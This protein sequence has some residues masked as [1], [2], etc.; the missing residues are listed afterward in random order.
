MLENLWIQ[1]GGMGLIGFLFYYSMQTMGKELRELHK[2]LNEYCFSVNRLVG[3]MEATLPASSQ[4]PATMEK[5]GD[6][7]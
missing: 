7:A 1:L 2:A 4:R 6:V 5:R 3:M